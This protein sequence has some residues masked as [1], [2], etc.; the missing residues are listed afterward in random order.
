MQTS[1]ELNSNLLDFKMLQNIFI[2]SKPNCVCL[3]NVIM[4]LIFLFKDFNEISYLTIYWTKITL[5]EKPT[6]K[7]IAVS[8]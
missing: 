3:Y 7:S 2:S 8:G 5:N 4:L 1:V 6:V